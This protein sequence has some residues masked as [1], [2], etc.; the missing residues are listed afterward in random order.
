MNCKISLTTFFHSDDKFVSS[1]NSRSFRHIDDEIIN[2]DDGCIGTEENLISFA[3]NNYTDE[4][5]ISHIKNQH[6][7]IIFTAT[8]K[9]TIFT[10]LQDYLNAL[11]VDI[12]SNFSSFYVNSK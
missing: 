5:F 2:D 9:L 8:L 3:W 6:S 12:D 7:S 11:N 10:Q 4:Q 1:F